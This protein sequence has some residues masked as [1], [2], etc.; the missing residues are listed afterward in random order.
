MFRKQKG[1]THNRPRVKT[2][3]PLPQEQKTAS[4][5]HSLVSE[6]SFSNQRRPWIEEK[7]R[8][9]DSGNVNHDV[10]PR[11]GRTNSVS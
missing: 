11:Q 2:L 4:E 10:N 8:G 9:A 6:P 1:G 5:G 3:A 7:Q